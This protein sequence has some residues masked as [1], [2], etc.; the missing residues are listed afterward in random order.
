MQ[1]A[2]LLVAF[3][4]VVILS[5][6]QATEDIR[7]R[8][9]RRIQSAAIC[10]LVQIP[11]IGESTR[12]SETPAP[13]RL[14]RRRPASDGAP[15]A[16]IEH[17]HVVAKPAIERR[18]PQPVSFEAEIT[19]GVAPEVLR[20]EV[21]MAVAQAGVAEP[22]AER[23]LRRAVVIEH[24][25]L[26]AISR[27]GSVLDVAAVLKEVELTIDAARNAG[28]SGAVVTVP[29]RISGTPLPRPAPE[30]PAGGGALCPSPD[31]RVCAQAAIF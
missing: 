25:Q 29:L 21:A 12:S 24:G 1:L 13:L 3:P 5:G 11:A 16:R 23:A 7:A 14:N 30:I 20:S 4:A 28:C 9:V 18:V 15:V 2:R 8:A 22:R 10:S 17:P 19:R 26:Q 27:S 6:C 31:V